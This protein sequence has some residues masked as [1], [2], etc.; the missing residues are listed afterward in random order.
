MS[1]YFLDKII[2]SWS[3]PIIESKKSETPK[4]KKV[5]RIDKK[6]ANIID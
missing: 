4:P 5:T 6:I 2:P 1:K 3:D